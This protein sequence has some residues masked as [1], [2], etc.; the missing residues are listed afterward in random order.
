MLRVHKDATLQPARRLIARLLQQDAVFFR[1][2]HYLDPLGVDNSD[3]PLLSHLYVFVCRTREFLFS[4]SF[5]QNFCSQG[6]L[7]LRILVSLPQF[8]LKDT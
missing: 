3:Q 6:V 2:H 1:E 8:L 4:N 5:R 7:P